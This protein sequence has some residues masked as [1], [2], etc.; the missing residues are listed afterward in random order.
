MLATAGPDG[1]L[2]T[3][4][5]YYHRDLTLFFTSQAGTPK[6]RNIQQEPRVSIGVF[7]PLVGQA[8]SRGAQL[9]GMAEV[10]LPG[11]ADFDEGM[12]AY[13]WQSDAAERG[14]SVL[15]APRNPLV[16]VVADRIVY[17][18]HWLRREGF[19]PR[20]HWSRTRVDGDEMEQPRG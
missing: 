9:F 1:P 17:T 6:L 16:R 3:P 18:E 2:A 4:V 8:S 12:A 13:R 5:R 14:R 19:A 15:E 20:Q 11:S 7:A 10:L